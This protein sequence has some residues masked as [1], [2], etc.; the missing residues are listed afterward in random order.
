MFEGSEFGFHLRDYVHQ[1]NQQG[2]FW[3]LS[4]WVLK[5]TKRE[6]EKQLAK[7]YS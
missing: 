5:T 4:G 2:G 7:H 3:N 1:G 6:V